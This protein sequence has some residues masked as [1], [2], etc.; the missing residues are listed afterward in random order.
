MKQLV[1]K[2][3]DETIYKTKLDNGL[4]VI[5]VHKPEFRN[6]VA[7]LG[8]NFGA[9]QLTQSV[10]GKL[11]TYNS[12][13]A[14]FLEHKLF[15][16]PDE[17]ILSVFTNMG[18][19]ANAF[20]SYNETIYYFQTTKELEKPLKT[21]LD[22]VMSIDLT[23]VGVDK[24]KGIIIEE[25]RMYQEMPFF[26]L[27]MDLL[28]SLFVNYPLRYDIAG[29]RDSVMAITKEELELAYKTNYHPSQLLLSIVTPTDPQEVLNIIKDNQ[30]QKQFLPIGNVE[31][32]SIN[33][34][35]KVNRKYHEIDMKVNA[36][37]YAIAFKQSIPFLNEL[38]AYKANVMTQILLDINFSKLNPEYQ[39]WI[40]QQII[41][42]LFVYQCDFG[43][44][45][46]YIQFVSE[47]EQ[48]DKLKS[49]LVNKMSNLEVDEDRLNQIKKRYLGESISDLSDFETFAIGNFR[50]HF[51]DSDAFEVIE[52]LE[53][54]TIDDLE[55]LRTQIS[56]ENISEVLIRK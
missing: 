33:E 29:T 56:V 52:I 8:T 23:Q 12:G 47:T 48:I 2:R 3:F 40:N 14:H 54:I 27:S 43:V 45:Y 53:N 20:T 51:L 17:D 11:H 10:N 16:K 22:F 18:A 44:D 46:G 30:S 42:D 49:L 24:E 25:L 6:S 28:E 15:E 50:A 9:K 4:T 7:L 41:N 13:I 32:P 31:T 34:P 55:H 19:Q 21:L 38:D 5:L 36:T 35:S 37:K 39:N 1:N 26:R